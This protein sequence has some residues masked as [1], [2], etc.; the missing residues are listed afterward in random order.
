MLQDVSCT[1]TS[2]FINNKRQTF[3][4]VHNNTLATPQPIFNG[5]S[6]AEKIGSLQ[7]DLF[8]PPTQTLHACDAAA[9][10]PLRTL[11][12]ADKSTTSGTARRKKR[13]ADPPTPAK[14][15]QS[16]KEP[17]YAKPT[18]KKKRQ[19]WTEEPPLEPPQ[20]EQGPLN[21]CTLNPALHLEP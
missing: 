2:G 15:T 10:P 13:P 16:A 11:E 5:L 6:R 20:T 14:A 21:T 12:S 9:A 7:S 17:Q 1:L 18:P 3:L 4:C 19:V 8:T